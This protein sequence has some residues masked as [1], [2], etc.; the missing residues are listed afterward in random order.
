[1]CRARDETQGLEHMLGKHSTT[2]IYPKPPKYHLYFI[3]YTKLKF[4]QISIIYK[5]LNTKDKKKIDQNWIRERFYR[6][7]GN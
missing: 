2:E 4:R 7:K 3:P 5:K 6:H 1:V